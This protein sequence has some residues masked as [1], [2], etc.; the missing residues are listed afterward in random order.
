MLH[1]ATFLVLGILV[2][3]GAAY[4][5]FWYS[6]APPLPPLSATVRQGT[7]SAG[8]RDRTYLIYVPANLRPQ[9]PLVIVLHGSGMDGMRM[10]VCTGDEF[11][12]LLI[13]MDL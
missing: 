13:S 4:G 12:C 11:E 8:G 10:W 2:L 9:A 5:Y 6:P 7:L 1:G 3:V